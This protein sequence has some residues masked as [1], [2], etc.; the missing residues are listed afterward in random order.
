MTVSEDLRL[1]M[2]NEDMDF[3]SNKIQNAQTQ[4]SWTKVLIN[5]RQ[6]NLSSNI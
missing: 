6:V 5:V 1:H 3:V 4:S 2:F